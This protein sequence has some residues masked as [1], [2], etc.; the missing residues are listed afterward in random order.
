MTTLIPP[1]QRYDYENEAQHRQAQ[2][3]EL[4]RTHKLG[5]DLV[6]GFGESPFNLVFS[7]A[8]G[9]EIA[10]GM[11]SQSN[12]VAIDYQSGE[13]IATLL[14]YGSVD[15]APTSLSDLD[16][17]AS[18]EL[19][20][21]RTDLG[22]TAAAISINAA[23]ISDGANLLAAI[24][25]ALSVETAERTSADGVLQQGINNRATLGALA[26]VE[27]DAA[28]GRAAIATGL[29]TET[30]ARIAGDNALQ[31]NVNS[32][33][34]N[35]QL[36]AV[37]TSLNSALS[38][39]EST[40][41]AQISAVQNA[42][43]NNQEIIDN[44]RNYPADHTASLTGSPQAVGDGPSDYI[45]TSLG[46]LFIGT[47]SPAFRPLAPKGVIKNVSGRTVRAV[48]R[49]RTAI[50]FDQPEGTSPAAL[51]YFVDMSNDFTFRSQHSF[52]ALPLPQPGAW[53]TTVTEFTP[54]D[55]V[56][57][58]R[59]I[60]QVRNNVTGGTIEISSFH[61]IATDPVNE[62]AVSVMQE[63]FVDN[64]GD[65]I[66]AFRVVTAAS[67]GTPATLEIVSGANGSGIRLGG[68][69]QIGG[70]LVVN[71]TITSTELA[72]NSVTQNLLSNIA[73]AV[74]LGIGAWT[75]I[76][77]RSA[78]IE[79]GGTGIRI[80][81]VA[82]ISGT[83]SGANPVRLPSIQLR[84]VRGSSVLRTFRAAAAI[85]NGGGSQAGSFIDYEGAGSGFAWDDPAPG[86]HTYALQAYVSAG[87]GA[88]ASN[89]SLAV[90]EF[91]R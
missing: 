16:V 49:W 53:Q 29:A 44:F 64:A 30:A 38:T 1:E 25:T 80:E 82:D 8:A 9:T 10:I 86:A 77:S 7:N 33:A 15:G 28:S 2:K 24:E 54:T 37:E 35:A 23:A 5:Q 63:A 58:L 17:E 66:A 46:N 12:L 47:P 71:G 27:T 36:D 56:G 55:D 78:N 26:A 13:A 40:L 39:S 52:K 32:R 4:D 50:A 74:G 6:L 83:N 22:D 18:A 84:I 79:A 85:T 57:W 41:T 31:T 69:T 70:D 59:P 73:G 68:D 14:D 42:A 34:T 90:T 88:A 67:G 61:V 65:A 51:L 21:L 43:L 19:V 60:F 45:L 11:D 3:R 75:T 91:K 81:G 89:R 62:S 76:A 72:S 48:V 20:S 87:S